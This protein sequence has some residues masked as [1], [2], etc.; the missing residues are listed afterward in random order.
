MV[1][2]LA[3]PGTLTFISVARGQV[4]SLLDGV[5]TQYS[6]NDA[7]PPLAAR[8]TPEVPRLVGMPVPPCS[9]LLGRFAPFGEISWRRGYPVSEQVLFEVLVRATAVVAAPPAAFPKAAWT[10]FKTDAPHG[11]ASGTDAPG[12]VDVVVVGAGRA[13]VVVVLAVFLWVAWCEAE[14]VPPEQAASTRPD[15]THSPRNARR[16]PRGPRIVRRTVVVFIHSLPSWCRGSNRHLLI[17]FRVPSHRPAGGATTRTN[18]LRRCNG[19]RDRGSRA[20]HRNQIP[21]STC[22]NTYRHGSKWNGCPDRH[23]HVRR[24]VG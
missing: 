10:P 16:E 3:E 15:A 1:T 20:D 12:V 6:M 23:G 19:P 8:F 2:G 21:L 7:T 4:G 18:H 11:A 17:C 22:L 14:G 5:A 13:V 9:T 24:W